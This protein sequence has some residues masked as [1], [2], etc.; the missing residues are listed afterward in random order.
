MVT[1]RID[2]SGMDQEIEDSTP[3][4]APT[5]TELKLRCSVGDLVRVA[6]LPLLVDRRIGVPETGSEVSTYFDTADLTLFRAGMILRVR[7]K[8]DGRLIQTIK[9]R[10]ETAGTPETRYEWEWPV[11]QDGPDLSVLDTINPAI[12]AAIGRTRNRLNPIFATEITRTTWPIALEPAG[13]ALIMIDEGVVRSGLRTEAISEVELELGTG[14]A[15]ALC[16]LAAELAAQVPVTIG[17]EAKSARG[18]RLASGTEPGAVKAVRA[19]LNPSMTAASAF[20]AICGNVVG[21]LLDNQPCVERTDDPG[22]LRQMRIAMRRLRA[23]LGLFE[24]FASPSESGWVDHS[25]RDLGRVFGV[26]RDCDVLTTQLLPD[27]AATTGNAD[28]AALLTGA[29]EPLRRDARLRVRAELATSHYT[30]LVLLL[31]AWSSGESWRQRIPGARDGLLDQPIGRVAPL[32]LERQRQ[33]VKRLGRG[34][35]EASIEERHTLRKAMKRLRYGAEFFSSLYPAET[36][37]AYLSRLGRVLDRLGHLNDTAIAT[38]LLGLLPPPRSHD[39]DE[40][41]RAFDV[42]LGGRATS[43]APKLMESWQRYKRTDPFWEI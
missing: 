12:A 38:G 16:R 4:A 29:I 30:R 11:A 24:S 27:F 5:E 8:T 40:A 43:A 19:T 2:V 17:V 41:I 28:A 21:H 22:G 31:G 23:L 13:S 18:Y 15:E 32:L 3:D 20:R 1:D 33:S 25:I 34:L 37:E 14:T 10:A 36:A 39:L 9:A 7:R 35:T 26:A 42:W 6:D